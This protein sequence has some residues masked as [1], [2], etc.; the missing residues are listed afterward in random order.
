MPLVKDSDAIEIEMAKLQGTWIQVASET[1]GVKNAPDEFGSE[2]RVTFDGSEYIV[3]R[4]DGSVVIKGRYRVDPTQTPKAID[5]TDTLGDDAGKTLPA[6]YYLEE[7]KL[8]FCAADEG[9]PRPTAFRT[10]VGQV[11]RIHQRETDLTI[12]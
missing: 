10:A 4:A 5:W 1:D 7:N 3:R 2:P 11:L 6:I 9:A 12:R 8:V